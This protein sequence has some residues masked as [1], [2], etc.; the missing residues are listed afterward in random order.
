MAEWNSAMGDPGSGVSEKSKRVLQITFKAFS[1]DDHRRAWTR[2]CLA[3]MLPR[4]S[5]AGEAGDGGQPRGCQ[6]ADEWH[7]ETRVLAPEDQDADRSGSPGRERSP[8]GCGRGPKGPRKRRRGRRGPERFDADYYL[9]KLQL[10]VVEEVRKAGGTEREISESIRRLQQKTAEELAE[11]IAKR[12]KV[13]RDSRT[14]RRNSQLYLEWKPTR[15]AAR[16]RRPAD[17]GRQ[18]PKKT[19]P[20]TQAD[21]ATAAAINGQLSQRETPNG[22]TH[23]DRE[24]IDFQNDAMNDDFLRENGVLGDFEPL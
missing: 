16:G 8:D 18:P 12:F 21:L 2:A 11:E 6:P 20:R 3:G 19:P 10:A 13:H 17:R 5:E 4:D 15:E 24:A 22:R 14:F 23:G 9:R 1:S 7:V